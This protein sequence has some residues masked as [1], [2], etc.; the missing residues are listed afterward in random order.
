VNIMNSEVMGRM[1]ELLI[2]CQ[3]QGCQSDSDWEMSWY[4]S[5]TDVNC[6][7]YEWVC[8]CVWI[9]FILLSIGMDE[10]VFRALVL[11]TSGCAWWLVDRMVSKWW[12]ETMKSPLVSVLIWD[13]LRSFVFKCTS[14][15]H[16]LLLLL[17]AFFSFTYNKV[18]SI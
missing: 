3:F 5:L 1:N 2:S 18:D 9:W 17:L 7:L 12:V 8:V 4:L 6:I 11:K 16:I 13:P 14:L 10:W 15:L